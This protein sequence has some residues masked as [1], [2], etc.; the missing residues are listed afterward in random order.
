MLLDSQLYFR[1]KG[2]P[3]YQA[4][5]L[6]T[7]G[8]LRLRIERAHQLDYCFVRSGRR[9]FACVAGAAAPEFPVVLWRAEHFAYRDLDDAA[10]HQLAGL[11]A[12][13]VRILAG[14]RGIFRTDTDIFAGAVCGSVG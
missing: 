6:R 9:D 3:L 4:L 7:I 11:P 10:G 1:G 2:T 13:R 8:G 5:V 12:D 14:H